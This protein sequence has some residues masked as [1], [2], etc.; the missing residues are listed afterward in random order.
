[1]CDME[2]L[3]H[4]AVHS[5]MV[6]RVALTLVDAITANG[7]SLDRPLITA[8]ALLHDITKTRSFETRE[9][10]ARTGGEYLC[11]KG[12]P[13]V[14]DAVAQHVRLSAYRGNGE[15]TPA[16]IV[17]YA[18]KR[19]LHDRIVSMKRR[20]AYIVERYGDLP[21]LR[22]KLDWLWEKSMALEQKLFRSLPFPPE[23]IEDHLPAGAVASDLAAFQAIRAGY[24]YIQS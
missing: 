11:E 14:G 4:I 9:D 7:I 22:R 2:M 5:I 24:P 10:H 16:E 15:P 17:N 13:E 20:M 3:E 8:S 19:V 12:Y 21:D 1:M 23:R 18:D 6:Q